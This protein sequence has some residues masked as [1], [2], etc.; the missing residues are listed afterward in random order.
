[1][2]DNSAENDGVFHPAT[3]PGL[4]G[5]TVTL[6]GTDDQGNA[7]NLTTTT[8]TINGQA[9]SYVYS[10]LRPSNGAGYTITETGTGLPSN[11]LDGKDSAPGSLGG[12]EANSYTDQVSAI[13]VTAG[14][15]GTNY[16]FGELRAASV[17]GVVFDN[18]AENDGVFHAATDPGINGVTVTLTGTDDQGNAVSLTQVTSTI[19]GQAGS[20]VFSG[21]RPSNA[22]GYTITK[23]GAGLP[24][25]YVEGKNGAPGSLGGNPSAAQFTAIPVPAGANGFGYN[26]SELRRVTGGG[27]SPAPVTPG[28][29]IVYPTFLSKTLLLGSGANGTLTENVLFVNSLYQ[30]MLGRSPDVAEVNLCVFQL[31]AG[32]SP[33]QVADFVWLCAHMPDLYRNILVWLQEAMQYMG[34]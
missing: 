28:N 3:D 8:A 20:Y 13:P 25:N 18:S 9:G 7:V 24:G 23:T 1:M 10:G 15:K 21:L 30:Q 6:T 27:A 31:D 4:N 26:F 34:M 2:F 29:P 12:K 16:S 5:V 33:E 32:V 11:F 14:A 17:S 22:A 19:N